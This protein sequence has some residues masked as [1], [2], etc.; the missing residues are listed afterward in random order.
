MLQYI[1]FVPKVP[2]V[3]KVRGVIIQHIAGSR[4][5]PARLLKPWTLLDIQQPGEESG[6]E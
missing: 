4:I 3:P 6:E 5:L 2:K 1:S